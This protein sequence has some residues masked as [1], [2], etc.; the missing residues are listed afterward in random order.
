MAMTST[1]KRL[2]YYGVPVDWVVSVL[3]IHGLTIV[4]QCGQP[5][6]E[7]KLG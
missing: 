7:N 3:G 6:F 2:V 5:V 1:G 4:E